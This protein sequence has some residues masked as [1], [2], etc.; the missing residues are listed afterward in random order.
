MT[1]LP[2]EQI[3]RARAANLYEVAARYVTLRPA[4]AF[5]RMQFIGPCPI[6]RAGDDRFAIDVR[7]GLWSCR[8]CYGGKRGKIA[9]GDVVDL[10][11]RAEGVG[12]AEAVERL[13]PISARWRP[14]TRGE[15]AIAATMLKA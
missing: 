5:G 11:M 8:Q 4:S 3:E 12:F 2:A 1:G 14:S 15:V 7:K 13:S 10:V 9:G 6:C